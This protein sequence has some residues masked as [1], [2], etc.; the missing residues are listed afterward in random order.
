MHSPVLRTGGKI[1]P[2]VTNHCR[3]GD[4]EYLQRL[5]KVLFCHTDFTMNLTLDICLYI[6]NNEDAKK[7]LKCKTIAKKKIP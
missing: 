4:T 7:K 6:R 1:K 2:R 3:F 5:F